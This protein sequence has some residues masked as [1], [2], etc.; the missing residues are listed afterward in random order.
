M[1]KQF[2]GIIPAMLTVFDEKGLLDWAGNQRLIDFLISNGVHGIFALGTSG[3]FSNLNLEERKQFAEFIVKYINKRV[4]VLIGTGST[5]TREACEFSRYAQEV[6]ADAVTV[7]VPYYIPLAERELYNH[8]AQV[9]GAVDI[10]VLIYNYP[11]LT[12]QNMPVSLIARLAKDFPNIIGIKATIDSVSYLRELVYEVKKINPNFAVFT[13]LED[14][15][16]NLLALGGDGAMTA[17]TN[18][19]PQLVVGEYNSYLEGNYEKSKQFAKQLGVLSRIYNT[20]SAM[21]AMTKEA[22][23]LRGIDINSSV[24][25]PLLPVGPKEVDQIRQ[26]FKEARL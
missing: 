3:E 17:I 6:G 20:G 21:I 11:A 1:I 16:L 2:R 10:P 15:L 9:A 25:L 23:R 5:N 24:R 22:C 26:L 19:A 7:V 8:Y 18:F 12:G 4:P 13:G 14:H